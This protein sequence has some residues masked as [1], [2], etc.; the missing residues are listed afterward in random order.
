MSALADITRARLLLVLERHE[1]TVGEMCAVVQLPQS[2]VSRHLKVLHDERWIAARAEGTSRRYRMAADG[3]DP[4][5]RRLWQVVRDQAAAL[6]AAG[7]DARRLRTVL[8][9]RETKSQR[10]FSSAA[11]QWDRLRAELFGQRA[12]LMG[13]LGLL[14][15]DWAVG[16]LGCG[17]GQVSAV[18]A[19]FVGSVVAVDNSA[20]M[21]DAARERLAAAPNVEA[22]LGDLEA[23]PIEDASLDA[24]V[25]VLVLPY[26]EQP[27]D[28][29]AEAARV[30][31]PAGRLLVVDMMPHGREDFR[32]TLGHL[33]QGFA[34]EQVRGWMDGAGLTAARYVPLPP[35]AAA[36]GPTLFAASARRS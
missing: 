25:L 29:I 17:T 33:W 14:D 22:R 27:A 24:A 12:E 35:D 5:A 18:L 19:P 31:R 13:L 2:T 30:L 26:V 8:A 15:G 28:V 10:F 21:L 3:V 16:D 11:G 7:E 20:A 34:E 1:L 36:K 4:G 9:E 32:Q 6:P 23:L